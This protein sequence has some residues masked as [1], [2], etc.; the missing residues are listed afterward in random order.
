M[1]VLGELGQFIIT[2]FVASAGSLDR[3]T[4]RLLGVRSSMWP[5]YSVAR[6]HRRGMCRE[7]VRVTASYTPERP[8]VRRL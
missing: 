3:E 6:R 1:V 4:P 7:G 8:S 5:G 2:V